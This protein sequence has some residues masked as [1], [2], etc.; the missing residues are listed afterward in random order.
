MS[1]PALYWNWRSVVIEMV[2]VDVAKSDILSAA[3][4]V[5]NAKGLT[6]ITKSSK[7]VAGRTPTVHASIGPVLTKSTPATFIVFFVAAGQDAK[8]VLT[9]LVQQW[10]ASPFA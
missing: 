5:M 4:T 8:N 6:N 1:S 10:D 2:T 3:Q 9:G 7:D